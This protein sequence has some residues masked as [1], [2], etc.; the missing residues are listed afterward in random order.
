MYFKEPFLFFVKIIKA[1]VIGQYTQ[2]GLSTVKNSAY[3][4]FIFFSVFLLRLHYVLHKVKTLDNVED[5]F[6]MFFFFKS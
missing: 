6:K 2:N 3:V 5:F 1:D 4:I